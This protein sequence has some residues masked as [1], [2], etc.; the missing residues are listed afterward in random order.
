VEAGFEGNSEA[1]FSF[2]FEARHDRS[3][4]RNT[5]SRRTDVDWNAQPAGILLLHGPSMIFGYFP[6]EYL[7]AQTRN[8]VPI[9]H[10]GYP[11]RVSLLHRVLDSHDS[12]SSEEGAPRTSGL[13]KDLGSFRRCGAVVADGM[14]GR[15]RRLMSGT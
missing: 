4:E 7:Y 13:W 8:D 6:N 15:R 12:G 1:P 2:F 14:G 11:P 10:R 5:V 9:P 3:Y